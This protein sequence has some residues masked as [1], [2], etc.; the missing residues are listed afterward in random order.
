ML[1]EAVASQ[2]LYVTKVQTTMLARVTNLLGLSVIELRQPG[3]LMELF[4]TC[5]PETHS[6]ALLSLSRSA[7]FSAS[8]R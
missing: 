3:G 8:V 7:R 4:V 6:Q 1:L 2:F 5:V